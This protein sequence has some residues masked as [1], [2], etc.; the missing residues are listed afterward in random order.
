MAIFTRYEALRKEIKALVAENEELKQ[1][2]LLLRENQELKSVLRDQFNERHL[3]PPDFE[4]TR[5]DHQEPLLNQ[6]FVDNSNWDQSQN[7]QSTILRLG[8][9]QR[10]PSG[11][12]AQLTTQYPAPPSPP[13]A[14]AG[15]MAASQRCSP[16]DRRSPPRYQVAPPS[17]AGSTSGE[18]TFACRPCCSWR[19]EASS[20]HSPVA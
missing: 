3:L 1:L 13:G 14:G 9:R 4:S 2:V 10:H 19:R 12:T 16:L 5:Q 17:P 8:I 6:A 18:C 11:L 7:A 20:W 15:A